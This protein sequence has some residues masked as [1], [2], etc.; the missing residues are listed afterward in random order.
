MNQH[1]FLKL[2]YVV[3][4]VLIV[5][6]LIYVACD[7]KKPTSSESQTEG[8]I[9]VL[10]QGTPYS[11]ETIKPELKKLLAYL[12]QNPQ[13]ITPEV[14]TKTAERHATITDLGLSGKFPSE[15]P[16]EDGNTFEVY[17][18]LYDGSV[19]AGATIEDA[20]VYFSLAIDRY[21]EEVTL[22][23]DKHSFQAEVAATSHNKRKG[24]Y[25]DE[26]SRRSPT[27]NSQPQRVDY[28]WFLVGGEERLLKANEERLYQQ[29]F[30]SKSGLAKAD[31]TTQSVWITRIQVVVEK[32][33]GSNDEFEMYVAP[34]TSSYTFDATTIFVFDGQWRG[35]RTGTSRFYPDINGT[36]TYTPPHAIAVEILTGGFPIGYFDICAI[37][38]DCTAAVHKNQHQGGGRHAENINFHR[39]DVGT[40]RL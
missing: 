27:I 9:A 35:D 17:I 32:D 23:G 39:I 38:D 13:I 33:T 6:S 15:F 21:P 8:A 12:K 10:N 37:E 11:I 28:L 25:K 20:E 5:A 31:A 24:L 30:N 1:K 7:T 29:W 36:G 14:L 19:G 40:D 26:K 34:A 22:T 4:L 16:L 3:A 18:E 2:G